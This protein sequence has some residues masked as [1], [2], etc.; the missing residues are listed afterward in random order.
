MSKSSKL[1]N[2]V[3]FVKI[4]KK[5]HNCPKLSIFS[6]IVRNLLWEEQV[7]WGTWAVSVSRENCKS[8]CF[9]TEVPFSEREI[10]DIGIYSQRRKIPWAL[11]GAPNHTW[12]KHSLK[13]KMQKHNFFWWYHNPPSLPPHLHSF[14]IPMCTKIATKLI[15]R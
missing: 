8:Q 3:K 15:S 13:V 12:M 9:T 6:K 10:I 1:S 14:V 5:C 2:I 4:V 11:S 7:G